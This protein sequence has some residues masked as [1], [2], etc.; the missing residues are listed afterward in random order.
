MN[1][2]AF[3]LS[4]PR[5]TLNMP[6]LSLQKGRICAVIGANGSGKSSLLKALSGA[7]PAF[8]CP[9]RRDVSVSYLP[10]KP[11][12]FRMSAWK[13]ILLGKKDTQRAAAL[14]QALGI[15]HLC[16]RN[17]QRLS[18]GEGARV[19]LARCLMVPCDLRLLDE[20]TAAMDMEAALQAE[21]AIRQAGQD[22]CTLLV[23]HSPAQAA[24]LADDVL[25]LSHGALT[26]WGEA[27]RVLSSPT[28]SETKRFLAFAK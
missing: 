9:L 4:Y 25:F 22:C 28:Q 7:L 3:T 27:E 15:E 13:N 18:G 26:E 2:P 23:T 11:Y 21:A 5:F 6:Q 12:L 17:A 16:R 14:T 1:I 24:R 8:S 20:P 10:Q 19:A